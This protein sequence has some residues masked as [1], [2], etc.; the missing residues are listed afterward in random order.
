MI[1]PHPR[2]ALVAAL[3]ALVI[4]TTVS[5]QT[6][7]P[8]LPPSTQP[9]IP[10]APPPAPPPTTQPAGPT[11][12]PARIDRPAVSPPSANRLMRPL[13]FVYRIEAAH[14]LQAWYDKDAIRLRLEMQLGDETINGTLLYD[15]HGG[16]VRMDSDDGTTMV[17]DGTN[18]WVAPGDRAADSGARFKL[19]AWSYFLGAPF[20]MRDRGTHLREHA[21]V[22]IVNDQLCGAIL[23]TFDPETGDSPEDLIIPCSQPRTNRLVAIG[24]LVTYGSTRVV[25]NKNADNVGSIVYE[26]F[27]TVDGVTLATRWRFAAWDY[28]LGPKGEPRGHATLSDIAFV[29]PPEG[30]FDKPEGAVEDPPPGG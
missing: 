1:L 25:A 7:P 21:P 14:G 24:Y 30:A 4:A 26:D 5:A 6:L 3:A 19:R 10:P 2:P 11:S 8:D 20:K 23:M 13:E 22:P 18:A 9:A 16:R 17:F 28:D 29:T 15:M 12:R 27:E